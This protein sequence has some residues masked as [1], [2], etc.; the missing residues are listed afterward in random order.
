MLQSLGATRANIRSRYF[1]HALAVG[2]VGGLLGVALGYG[3][4]AVFNAY[5]AAS[6]PVPVPLVTPSWLSLGVGF[7]AAVGSSLL[8]TLYPAQLAARASIAEAVK[9]S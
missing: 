3:F 1:V 6:S 8:F 4:L 5:A 2:A 7:A 9:E